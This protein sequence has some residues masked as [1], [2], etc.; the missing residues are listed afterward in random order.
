MT[1]LYK[2]IIYLDHIPV[3]FLIYHGI[4]IY[5]YILFSKFKSICLVPFLKTK[6]NFAGRDVWNFITLSHVSLPLPHLR[7]VW[8]QNSSEPLRHH[9]GTS[10]ENCFKL[11]CSELHLPLFCSITKFGSCVS[12]ICLCR[13]CEPK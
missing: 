10:N 6:Q 12:H 5:T 7:L 8:T 11:A 1:F 9:C 4:R 3:S 13:L 2:C